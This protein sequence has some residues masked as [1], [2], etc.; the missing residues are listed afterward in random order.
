MWLVVSVFK[1]ICK[2]QAWKGKSLPK[3]QWGSGLLGPWDPGLGE[4]RRG[5]G[6]RPEP[7]LGSSASATGGPMGT[8]SHYRSQGGVYEVP[9]RDTPLGFCFHQ[10]LKLEV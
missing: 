9:G 4:G 6:A 3:S 5:G 2:L 8:S 10:M 1:P 7:A